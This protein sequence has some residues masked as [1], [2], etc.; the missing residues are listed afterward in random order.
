L[1]T[2]G[3]RIVTVKPYQGLVLEGRT[4]KIIY[5]VQEILP[6]RVLESVGVQRARV[7]G[8]DIEQRFNRDVSEVSE[9]L[10][11]EG[12]HKLLKVDTLRVRV[13]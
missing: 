7:I 1:A 2:Q 3:G 5:K 12:E 6:H 8:E 4:T 11:R 10:P 13:V 9:M